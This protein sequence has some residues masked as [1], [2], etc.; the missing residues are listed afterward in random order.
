MAKQHKLMYG[1]NRSPMRAHF[2][3]IPKALRNKAGL[4]TID[5]C[6]TCFR[7]DERRTIIDCSLTRS[8]YDP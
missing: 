1:L 4:S 7:L 2:Q 6:D 3:K 8:D 5:S